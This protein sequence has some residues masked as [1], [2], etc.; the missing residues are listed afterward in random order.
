MAFSE[1]LAA[2]IRL[3]V[4]LD[5]TVKLHSWDL[6]RTNLSGSR[7]RFHFARPAFLFVIHGMKM[8]SINWAREKLEKPFD[9][10]RERSWLIKSWTQFY[11]LIVH[12]LWITS[13]H[14]KIVT[15]LSSTLDETLQRKREEARENPEKTAKRFYQRRWFNGPIIKNELIK[16]WAEKK[17]KINKNCKI[18]S[19]ECVNA[20]FELLLSNS[21]LQFVLRIRSKAELRTNV[22]IVQI[23]LQKAETIENKN[24]SERF[25]KTPELS[26]LFL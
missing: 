7:A 24:S 23:Y 20:F 22:Y 3:C 1:R 10:S 11:Q 15:N 18:I 8:L 25:R 2:K 6:Y 26:K 9:N 17:I 4:C 19:F 14:R 13:W 5:C 12:N 16:W 21:M